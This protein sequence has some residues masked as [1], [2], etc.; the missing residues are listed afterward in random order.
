MRLLHTEESHT[1]NFEIIE[2][3]DDRIPPYAILSHTWE[4]EE[5]TFQDMH[6]DQ[7]HTR[8]K[9]GYS[10]IQRCCHLAKTE[11]FEYVWID[12][13]CIDKTSSAELS[14]AINSMYR[15]YQD[16]EV[17]Y[18]YLADVPSK[19]FKES[20]WFTRGWTL[21]ELI[22]PR[23]I[24]FLD[25]NWKELGNKAD[26]Q[27]AICECTRIPIGV[28]S[29]DEDIESFSIAQR[30]SWAAERVTTRVEDRAYSL[31][32]IFGVNIPLIYGE[33]E[34]AFIRLQEEIMRISDDHSLFAWTSADNRGG[35][36]ATSPAAFIGSHNIVRF[37]PFDPFN[38]PFAGT[39][40]GINLTV[41]FMGIGPRG[42]GL[43][44]LHCK[45]EGEGERLIALYVRDSE[46][47]TMERFERVCSEGFN[48]LDLRKYRPS[49]YPMRQMIIRAGRLARHRKSKGCGKCDGITPE[50]YSDAKLMTLMEFENPSA[51]LQAAERGLEDIVWLLLT[52]SDVEGDCRGPGGLT[53][54]MHASRNGHETIAKMLVARRDVIA[55][56]TDDEGRT[57]LWWA[58]EAGHEAIVKM[59]VEKGIAIEGRDRDGWTPLTIAS[60][61]GHEG[62]VGLL[63][64][65]GVAIEE[66]DLRGGTLLSAA[67]W[68]GYETIVK[69][70]L[71]KGASIEM[72]DGEGRTPLILAA[73]TGY[74]NIAR[75]LL[76]KGAVVEKQDQA[77]RTPLFLAIWAGYENI[78]RMLLEKGAVVE[79]R[80]QS[81]KTPL[82]GA[83]DRKHEAVGRVLLENGADIEAR[84]AH[85]QTALLLAAWH[86]SDTFAK[87]L[88]ENGANIE[89]RD[90][91]D[92][93]ALFLAVRKGHIAIVKLLLQHGAEANIRNSS[94]RTPI[95]IA[96]LEGQKAIVELLR[97]RLSSHAYRNSLS[98]A[99]G[100]FL[101]PKPP[102]RGL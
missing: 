2:F 58:A 37:N 39:S 89:A 27:Q 67:V 76:E 72:Q 5:V 82:L 65:K 95:A 34:T 71:D 64:D 29:G 31:L 48:Q 12:S 81:G 57:P 43:A 36:L 49:Q 63:L 16:A 78:V 99:V 20:R 61:N 100:R 9:K 79:A 14:E 21:Q 50:I 56:S 94:G 62:T 8:Q 84:D 85:S 83:A 11:G 45:E 28:L 74:E 53:P 35:L 23:K 52:R 68:R 7:L 32:G 54:L 15:W 10:K 40:T 41:R 25:E 69:V 17:C 90:K 38:A 3:T 4:G 6:A 97:E 66:Q 1:G 91:Q 96:K 59:L 30:M 93:T 70:L 24:T 18:A 75:V 46:F 33:R 13:C 55:D 60:K 26:L 42:L 73:W 86:G 101:A 87:M 92:E 44:I 22:A 102:N 77:G 88:L 47:L 80:D 19:E 98:M 51:L